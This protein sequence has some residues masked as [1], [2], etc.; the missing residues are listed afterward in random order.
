MYRIPSSAIHRKV[1]DETVILATA[2]SQYHSLNDTA[3]F[4]FDQLGAGQSVDD[5]VEALIGEFDVAQDIARRDVAA[6]VN[7]LLSRGLLEPID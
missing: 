5:T 4:V 3:S 2:T 1:D 7:D 6:I